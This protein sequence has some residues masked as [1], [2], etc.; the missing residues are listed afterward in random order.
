MQKEFPRLGFQESH[1]RTDLLRKMLPQWV[2][3]PGCLCAYQKLINQ[4]LSL[5]LQF[6]EGPNP[7]TFMLPRKAGLTWVASTSHCALL[8]PPVLIYFSLKSYGSFTKMTSRCLAFCP[9]IIVATL[10]PRMTSL[11]F[12]THQNPGNLKDIAQV[13]LF[14]AHRI[15][16]FF[17][18]SNFRMI[19]VWLSSFLRC[20]CLY[21]YFNLIVQFFFLH[22]N[23]FSNKL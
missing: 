12:Y 7:I 17:Y 2:S 22:F 20:C 3:E 8:L 1:C 23:L 18:P 19:S 6:L 10:L 14:Q 13:L 16:S 21:L 9:L 4:K 15:K 5:L 11:L